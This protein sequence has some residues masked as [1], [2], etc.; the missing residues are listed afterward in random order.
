VLTEHGISY[1]RTLTP[2]AADLF[3][4][5][6][7]SVDYDIT[8]I[9]GADGTPNK[10]VRNRGFVGTRQPPA[11]THARAMR[12]VRVGILPA[13]AVMPALDPIPALMRLPARPR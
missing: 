9:D 13:A 8:F 12:P 1:K 11:A 10:Y 5:S 2:V 4:M 7:A 3:M 6:I